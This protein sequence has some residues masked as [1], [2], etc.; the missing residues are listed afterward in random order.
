MSIRAPASPRRQ[1]GVAL[2]MALLLVAVVTVLASAILWR[3][4]I[5]VTQVKVLRE[6]RQA[7]RLVMGGVDWARSVLYERQHQRI[8]KDYLGE[9]WSTRVPPIPVA[10]GEISGQMFDEQSRFNMA[11]LL[12]GDPYAWEQYERLLRALELPPALAGALKSKLSGKVSERVRYMGPASLEGVPGYTP[13]VIEKLGKYITLL[14]NAHSKLNV[15]TAPLELIYAIVPGLS[16]EQA[17]AIFDRRAA[18]PFNH[19][20]DFYTLLSGEVRDA[21]RTDS[22]SVRSDFFRVEVHATFEQGRASAVALLKRK[23]GAWPDVVWMKR[24]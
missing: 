11:W 7:H 6:A 12:A 19:T 23:P 1:Q 14:P 17:K 9:A 20:P 15:N 2:L 24:P 18:A 10:G 3:V 22:I 16:F 5:W 13:E 21:F 4:D 8:R